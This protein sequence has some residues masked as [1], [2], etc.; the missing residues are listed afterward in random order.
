M[1]APYNL[2]IDAIRTL[3]VVSSSRGHL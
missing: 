2:Q 1:A 3:A